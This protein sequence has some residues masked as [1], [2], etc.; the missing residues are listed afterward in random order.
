MPTDLD[1]DYL[2][3]LHDVARMMRTRVDQVARRTMGMTRG[4][5]LATSGAGA[6]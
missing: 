4:G 1:H 3:L 2:F 5:S 6:N